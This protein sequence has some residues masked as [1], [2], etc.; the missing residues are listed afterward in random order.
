MLHRR[1][2]RPLLPLLALLF[3]LFLVGQDTYFWVGG[4][5]AWNDA[6]RWAREMGG[7]G[8]AGIPGAQDHVVIAPRLGLSVQLSDDAFC[9]DL[10]LRSG[11][12]Q[13]VLRGASGKAIAIGGSL[14][15]EGD[16]RWQMPGGARFVMR[17]GVAEIAPGRTRFEGP[18]LFDGNGTW[19]LLTD[20]RLAPGNVITLR[21]GTLLT[22][23][24]M[25]E[26]A[27]L[28][29]E[30]RGKLVLGG[31]VIRLEAGSAI[32]SRVAELSDA[33]NATILVNGT[34]VGPIPEVDERS[35]A[36]RGIS[37]C[38]VGPGQTQFIVNASLVSDYN[39]FGVSCKG[40]CN[41]MVTVTVTGGVGPFTYQW[42]SGPTT[43]TWNNVCAG[44]QI[45]IV[46]D[47]GQTVSCA[48]TVQVTDPP[49]LGA[50]FFGTT[51]PSCADV[52]DGSSNAFAVGGAP[53][54][55]YSWNNGAEFGPTATQL[56][57]GPNTLQL[58]D[59][60]NCVRD[61]IFLLNVLP[62]SPQ[63]TT[64]DATCFGGCDGQA[65]VLVTGG[66]GALTYVWTP[67]PPVGQGTPSVS[68]L[69]A[70]NWQVQVTDA[71]GCD[72]TVAFTIDQPPPIIPDP[73]QT[74]ASC[75]NACDATAMVDPSGT[76]GPYTYLWTPAPGGGQGT[77][78]ATGLCAGVTTV[79][80]TDVSTSCDTLV[81]FMIDA[82][83]ALDP[84]LT[85]TDA[86][87]SDV[88]DGVV[89]VAVSGGAPPYSFLWTPAPPTGQGTPDVSGL[90][91]GPW[92]VTITDITGCDTT[93]AFTID[94]PPPL[95]AALTFTEVSCAGACDASADAP[96]TGGTAPYTYLWSP[97]PPVGQGTPSVAQLCAGPWSVTISD[98]NGCDTT[99]SFTILEPPPLAALLSETDVACAGDCSGSV[100]ALVSGGTLPYT[101]LWS[102]APPFGQGTDSIS[103]LC[104]GAGQLLVTDGNGCTLTVPY[105]IDEPTPL[106]ISLVPTDASC[107]G[108]CDGSAT[109]SVSGGTPVYMYLWSPAPGG[110][111]GTANAT[112]LCAG[113]Y[114]L[115]VTD[116]NGCDSTISFV[117]GSP[118]PI[119]PNATVT[120]ANC[121]NTCD[122]SILLAPTGGTPPYTYAWVPVPP[123]GDGTPQATGLCAGIY[124]VTITGSGGC[125]TTVQFLI[126]APPPLT[127][128]LDIAAPT[129]AGDCN[130]SVTATIGGGVAPYT[131]LWDP[132]PGAGQGTAMASGMCPGAYQLTVMDFVG[133][134]TIIS[135]QLDAPLPID[136]QLVTT[137]TGCTGL[138][139]GTPTVTP[140]GGTGS[141]AS[142]TYLWS[143]PPP[144]GQGTPSVQGLCE[145]PWT[146]LITDSLGCDTLVPFVITTPADIDVVAT[147]TDATCVDNCDASVDLFVNGGVPPYTFLW[148]PTP[149]VGQGTQNVSGLCAGPISVLIGDAVGCDTLIEFVIGAPPAILPNEAV[150]N[151]TCNGPCD[152][153]I[154]FATSGGLPPYQ[155]FWTPVPPNGQ[156]QPS[157]I[158][159]CA[160]DYTVTITDLSGCDTTLTLTV[161]PQQ[162]LDAQITGMNSVCAFPCDGQATVTVTNGIPPYSYLWSPAPPSGQGTATA[163]GLCQGLWSVTVT[164]SAG[165]DTTLSVAIDKPF[166]IVPSLNLQPEDCTG[167]CTGA[168][169]VFPSGGNGG[170][171]FDWQPPPGGGQGTF[172]VTGLCAGTNYTITVTDSLGCDTT[173]AFTI[174][175]STPIVPNLSTVPVTCAGACDGSATVTPSGGIDPYTYDWTPDPPNGDGTNTATGLCAGN[176]SLTITDFSGCDTTINVLITEPAPIDAGAV[177]NPISC[178]GLCDGDI[179]LSPTGGTGLF[180]FLWTP[181]PPNGQGSNGA[182]G[183]CAGV[184]SVLIAD[185]NGCDT[186]FTFDLTEPPP[187]V[188]ASASLNS[189]CQI[190]SGEVSVQ[191]SGGTSGYTYEWT[192]QNNVVVGTDSVVTALCSG[193]YT[194]V[195]TDAGGCTSSV[196]VPVS[197]ADGDPIQA[198]G[199]PTSCPG[200]CDGS[201]TSISNCTF[202]P[203]TIDWFD[204]Q[205]NL[206]ASDTSGISGVCAGT[207]LAQLTN[208]QGCITIDT[209]VVVGPPQILPGLV[210]TSVSCGGT[211]DGTAQLNPTG[212]TGT[213]TFDWNPVPPNGNGT[214]VATGLCPGNYTVLIADSLGCDTLIAFDITGPTPILPN[215]VVDSIGCSGTCDGSIILGPTGGTAPYTF[216]WNPVP[217]NGQGSNGAFGLCAGTWSVTISDDNGCD[218]VAVFVLSEPSLLQAVTS[219]TTSQCQVC[220]G[221]ADVQVSGG[222]LPYTI[223]WTDA[224][225]TVV[226]NGPSLVNLCAGVY[227]VSITD[228]SGCDLPPMAV[229]VQDSDGEAIA[230]ADGAT[231]CSNN[232]DGEVSVQY[233]CLNGPCVVEWFDMQ[234]N[235]LA[236]NVDTLSNL[237]S[238]QYLVQVTNGNGCISVD[239][240]NVASSTTIVPNLSSTPVTCG[241]QCDGT[242][243][244]GPVGGVLPY[245][246]DWSPDPINGDGT[247]QATGLCAGVY[248]VLITD[249][250]G[251]DTTV[252]VL[253][254]GPPVLDATAVIDGVTC[255][256][257]CDGSI[258]L[259]P[260]GGV[261]LYQFFWTPVPPNG[262]GSNGAFNL[263]AGTY[264]VVLS[265]S[266]GC[267]TTFTYV[268][269]EPDPLVLVGSAVQSA[270][271]VCNGE[272]GAVVSGG[273]APYQ[274]SW[275]DQGGV[276]VGTDSVLIGLCAGIYTVTVT[277]STGCSEVLAMPVQDIDGETITS[278]GSG[279]T[280]STTCDGTA[281]V[282]FV[283][284]DPPCVIAWAD[285]QGVDINQAADTAVGLCPGTYFV[286]VT[287]GTGCVSI[288]TVTVIAPPPIVPNMSTTAASCAGICDGTATVGPTG[289]T[290]P[291]TYAWN[292]V[293]SNG[294]GTPQA[295]GLCAGTVNV[296]ITDS[297]GCALPV[298]ILILEPDTLV[299]SGTVQPIT[300]AGQCDASILVAPQGGT[301]PYTY[302]WTPVPPNGNGS[303]SAVAL[304]AGQSSVQVTDSSGCVALNTFTIAE[305]DTIQVGVLITDNPCFGACEGAVSIVILGGVAPYSITWTDNNGGIVATDT[306]L[307]DGLCTA[308]YQG[309]ITDAVGCVHLVNA[310]VDQ[311]AAIQAGLVVVGETCTGPCDG[312]A[313][314]SP[315]GGGG[316][317][318]Y[319]W[320]PPPPFGQGTDQV[321]GLCAGPWSVTISDA[322]GCDTTYAFTIDPYAPIAVSDSVQNVLCNGACDGA[323]TLVT[324]GG[325]GPFTYVW[326]PPPPS[327]QGTPAVSGLCPGTWSV[328][329]ADSVGCD[330]AFSFLITEPVALVAVLDTV[331][332]ATCSTS[333]DGAIAITVS[334]GT[335]PYTFLWTGPAGFISASEDLAA[336][337]PGTYDLL[338]TGQGGC[339]ATLSVVVNSLS[340]GNVD[341]GAD[342]I[343]CTGTDVILDGSASSGNGQF[344]WTDGQGNFVS[345]TLVHPIG[346]PLPGSY[347]Y[348][349]TLVD[350]PCTDRDTVLITIL[351]APGADAGP[352][353]TIFAPDVVALGGSPSGPPG[354]TFA[355]MPDSLVSDPSAQN[356]T[357]QPSQTTWYYLTV[358]GQNGCVSIDS[359]LITVVPK[360]VVTNGFTPNGDGWNDTWVIDLIDLFPNVEVEVYNRWGELLFRS[361]GYKQPWDGRYSGGL[362]PVGTYYYVIQ[363]NDPEFPDAFT[364]PLTIVR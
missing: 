230:G 299:A 358:T 194:V 293:P 197:D 254:T 256:G 94:S 154:T 46:T 152:G 326:D 332:P 41:G 3:P 228:A 276:V 188:L 85:I 27:D 37:I 241:N 298:D 72:T 279:T 222:T 97:P 118:D 205:G 353:A 56:C 295:L 190:C 356:P 234:G 51:L 63:L 352:D 195:V 126:D 339:T 359:V 74:D 19:S 216:L 265:D 258:V 4:D 227:T 187:L 323:I 181:V 307:I 248:Q 201:V 73:S 127:A 264:T 179:I 149:P 77:Q 162:A 200:S 303:D 186:T 239:T 53:P 207:Y 362:V 87:C 44:N 182:F 13:L 280:C 103:G 355:W 327:G 132:A 219:S 321:S 191:A 61:T 211:C 235:S 168:A 341:A 82:P 220:N 29:Q 361:V 30:G 313:S 104:A 236:Q 269:G 261:G 308:V 363:L 259:T 338:V 116:A 49:L 309:T 213:L 84:V 266:S 218:T 165:C 268:L 160:G 26:A 99:L 55:V 172:F 206:I 251:C 275:T 257:D 11:A 52:C 242:A 15:A 306:T 322:L 203:C 320:Q 337:D 243:T 360:F 88:C 260:T 328:T 39:G 114:D 136:P 231:N 135:F 124:E 300:C 20:L 134:D 123:N 122:G 351:D 60:N 171:T 245:T 284:S 340:A 32:E 273:N 193:V 348:I 45:V 150:T 142:F 277:D 198:S 9:R 145:G 22:N 8:G 42:I 267:D 157:G 199:L 318:T 274:Y 317:Y 189:Q 34:R 71:N 202:A 147:I 102:P 113:A 185:A 282:A 131:Y 346:Q 155:Y 224:N 148:T 315:S 138:C 290:G 50:I 262:Q 66:T 272:A 212:G 158:G 65:E 291:F 130:G 255:N 35:A 229:P 31:S 119:L 105:T 263:C 70:G 7:A 175:P 345:S 178:N 210:V 83:P 93:V 12:G 209:A 252:S 238:G 81:T 250:T 333:M 133:C 342:Q 21:R 100:S 67:L 112:G 128:S 80:I 183:L 169:A 109:V 166:P 343:V 174:D 111:Q 249:S 296:V 304:C 312:Q 79:L 125:D 319:L 237:C 115:T 91:P 139:F 54:Y 283:C 28:L 59:A 184:Y 159:L 5:G 347:T 221:T 336:L 1:T 64:T 43:A 270:C 110:G 214:P 164:D 301:A 117:I 92:S 2:L 137:E 98:V 101:L 350:G 278:V 349:L 58:T 281:S 316:G 325:I 314:V 292:P 62:L 357:S 329:I 40:Q 247:P 6:S 47:Q 226:G 68:Q 161:L 173:L 17:N 170:Y 302:D 48:A 311:P 271:Q 176:Y 310:Y 121:A 232:C 285:Q 38:G 140:T 354:A 215:A 246:Y 344:T 208:G 96:A 76:V 240:V 18:V 334:G 286:S 305:P 25:V 289:G 16:I 23:G 331:V 75:A 106:Q 10:S 57:A 217:P 78:S 108:T 297:L 90:C 33:G 69:C 153:T 177:V 141:A 107:D 204:D 146:V 120:D 163:T 180:T 129:C 244:V 167:P 144:V 95:D 14:H 143:P 223:T 335:A 324:S 330:T 253:I 86:T 233:T 192:D 24:N 225:N 151:E 156:G 89:S 196:V 36:Q 294:D 288:D 287:N 364:G